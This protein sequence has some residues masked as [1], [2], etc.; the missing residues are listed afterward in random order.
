MSSAFQ[1]TSLNL[2][3][4]VALADLNTIALRTALTGTSTFLD[5][6]VLAPGLH[7][8]Q[9]SPELHKGEF[10][11]CAAMTSGYV[12]RV[13]N[14]ATVLFLQKVGK[15]G[16]LTTLRVYA[17]RRDSRTS[18][19]GGAMAY[20][21]AVSMTLTVLFW[22]IVSLQDGWG[23]SVLGLLIFSRLLNIIVIRR[24]SVPGWFGAKEP[25]VKGDLLVLLSQDR[26]I[27]LQGDVDD[28]K[29]VTSGQWLRE[30]TFFE[31]SLVGF[32]TLLVY[33]DAALA[34]NAAQTSKLLLLILLFG[35]GGL[36]GIAN[37]CTEVLQMHGRLIEVTGLPKAYPRRLALAEELILKTGRKDWAVRVG[38]VQPDHKI[39]SEK[40]L[41]GVATM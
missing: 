33:L 13:E 18:S 25:G 23:V 40:E 11:A 17:S 22:V 4:L 35:S 9:N 10:P 27:R 6:L 38:M 21:A 16:H 30:P 24:R 8:Q 1:N 26:W 41:D 3:G 32:A 28:L 29:A 34:G 7:R 19:F 39:K 5:A 36:L 2:A 14:P 37:E 31:S 20:T 15:T 12:F